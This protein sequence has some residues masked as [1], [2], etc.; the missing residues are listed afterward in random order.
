MSIKAIK[1]RMTTLKKAKFK[2]SDD[3]KNIDKYRVASI[4]TE[5]HNISKIISLRIIIP[6]H[7]SKAIIS[8]KNRK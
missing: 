4:I 2:K 8:C 6:N 1:T 3:Q 7:D 5:Y